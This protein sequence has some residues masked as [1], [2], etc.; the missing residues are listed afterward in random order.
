[1]IFAQ[2]QAKLDKLQRDGHIA[3]SGHCSYQMTGHEILIHQTS[4]DTARIT[5][6][7]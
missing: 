3:A 2:S 5:E 4:F 1:M 6:L 7:R